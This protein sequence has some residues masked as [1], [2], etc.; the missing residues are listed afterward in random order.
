MAEIYKYPRTPHLEGSRFQPGDEDLDNVPFAEI[1]QRHLVVEEKLDGANSAISFLPDGELR[2]QSRGHFLLGGAAEKHFHLFKQWASVHCNAL[3]ERLSSR[4]IL[5]GEWLYAK[6][7]VF[8]NALPHYFMEFD[9]LDTATMTFLSTPERRKLLQDLPVASVPVLFSGVLKSHKQ[10][11]KMVTKSNFIK[12]DHIVQLRELAAERN[13]DQDRAVRETDSSTTM[14]GLYIKVE[15]DGIVKARYK[16]VRASF[17]T[18][19]LNAEGHWLAR[20]IIPNQLKDDVDLYS[21]QLN[22]E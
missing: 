9:I 11:T 8:Y 5:Y 14:E 20:P 4:Y 7:T 17:L 3:W 22:N 13:L 18:A 6:H 12:D 2:L 16:F 19:V 1:A 10:L 21:S 15:E